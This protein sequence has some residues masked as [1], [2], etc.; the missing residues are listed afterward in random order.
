MTIVDFVMFCGERL[1]V[2]GHNWQTF[3]PWNNY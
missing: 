2:Y 3:S 1:R